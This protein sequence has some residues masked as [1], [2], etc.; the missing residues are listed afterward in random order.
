MSSPSR[1]NISLSTSGKSLLELSPSTPKE[2]RFAIVT[3]AGLDAVDAAGVRCAKAC[4][5]KRLLRTAKSCGSDAPTLVSSRR[6]NPSATVARKPGHRGEH[7]ISRKTIAQG[8]PGVSGVPVYSCAL[9]PTT[10]AHEAAGASRTRHFPA[11]FVFKGVNSGHNSGAT[12]PRE[13][14]CCLKIESELNEAVA[15]TSLPSP[16]AAGLS[17]MKT[18]WCRVS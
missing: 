6:S 15:A 11:P 1:K 9:L 5:T 2:G 8:V 14:F 16:A 18:N 17:H 3:N 12:A 13:I 10:I 4:W 7:D